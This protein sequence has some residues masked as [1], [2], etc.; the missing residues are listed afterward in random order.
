ME[1]AIVRLLSPLAL[2]AGLSARSFALV[3]SNDLV[4][5]KP[6]L[7][8]NQW[9]CVANSESSASYPTVH[10]IRATAAP[11][12]AWED[13]R[14]VALWN[15]QARCYDTALG[16]KLAQ[17]DA[18]LSA[19]NASATSS[20]HAACATFKCGTSAICERAGL[21]SNCSTLDPLNAAF[22]AASSTSMDMTT[23]SGS[24]RAAADAANST[25]HARAV[26]TAIFLPT[27]RIKWHSIVDVHAIEHQRISATWRGAAERLLVS[28]VCK[29]LESL[30]SHRLSML[31][32]LTATDVPP[33]RGAR[34][35]LVTTWRS[36]LNNLVEIA[37]G[38]TVTILV[39]ECDLTAADIQS[40][41]QAFVSAGA[42]YVT[43]VLCTPFGCNATAVVDQSRLE[44]I[45]LELEMTSELMVCSLM[46]ITISMSKDL[47]LLFERVASGA[48]AH[49][50]WEVQAANLASAY[51]HTAHNII[52]EWR[53]GTAALRTSAAQRTQTALDCFL[54]ASAEVTDLYEAFTM[55][56]TWNEIEM[57]TGVASC[58]GMH[59]PTPHVQISMERDVRRGDGMRVTPALTAG[60]ASLNLT[61]R[62]AGVHVEATEFDRQRTVTRFGVQDNRVLKLNAHNAFGSA[63]RRLQASHL[64]IG[65][66]VRRSK[67]D[68]VYFKEAPDE[69]STVRMN[70]ISRY[71]S[72]DLPCTSTKCGV[73]LYCDAVTGTLQHVGIGAYSPAGTCER[74]ACSNMDDEHDGAMA[75][76]WASTLGF[77]APSAVYISSGNGTNRCN[78]V[79]SEAGFFLFPFG[80]CPPAVTWHG[81]NCGFCMITMPGQYSPPLENGHLRW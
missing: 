6:Y 32:M 40:R 54:H 62:E 41:V 34:N 59:G 29:Q 16:W 75:T 78:W 17:V 4:L 46:L 25:S 79:C 51:H 36:I 81:A 56:S 14:L 9:L 57:A 15:S 55:G 68:Q 70:E 47:L 60:G 7:V 38:C 19:S 2:L 23:V 24:L 5:G 58:R 69:S 27:E 13:R 71:L 37:N 67:G 72:E 8:G 28:S 42:K 39:P 33:N 45:Q 53:W 1:F 11:L 44:L 20:I 77:S 76:A 52:N 65:S 43:A 21:S 74:T 64:R 30:R 50:K 80:T 18:T 48:M 49:G 73:D 26:L 66:E 22:D 61:Y 12:Y 31:Q 35:E 3:P 10:A 63:V